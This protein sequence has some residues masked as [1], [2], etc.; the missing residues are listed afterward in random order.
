M[1]VIP[2]L[3]QEEKWNGGNKHGRK[4]KADLK[5]GLTSDAKLTKTQLVMTPKFFQ[6]NRTHFKRE[7]KLNTSSTA[8]TT[9]PQGGFQR[10]LSDGSQVPIVSY[11]DVQDGDWC[12]VSDGK[13]KSAVLVA[14]NVSFFLKA[15]N[16]W[17]K[18]HSWFDREVEAFNE[19]RTIPERAKTPPV[20]L[21]M[22]LKFANPREVQMKLDK[23]INSFTH[24]DANG[25]AH[26][27]LQKWKE[28]LAR[29][30]KLK[31]AL[32]G[33]RCGAPWYDAEGKILYHVLTRH[34]EHDGLHKD[35]VS[36]HEDPKRKQYELDNGMAQWLCCMCHSGKASAESIRPKL[37]SC[38]AGDKRGFPWLQSQEGV[39]LV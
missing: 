29:E 17:K 18:G 19:D 14:Y 5:R 36:A 2:W 23:Y 37:F 32:C 6:E 22:S 11:G 20:Y 33:I 7:L 27:V 15:P 4:Q 28:N 31:C 34:F 12:V 35:H 1:K 10:T 26:G 39:N 16:V 38:P 3:I 30:G 24:R 9:W 25:E 21:R 8:N 13:F